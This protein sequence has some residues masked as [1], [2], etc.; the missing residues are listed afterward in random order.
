M[1]FTPI[2]TNVDFFFFFLCV[3]GCCLLAAANVASELW[4]RESVRNGHHTPEEEE[5]LL[6]AG[7]CGPPDRG[8]MV[9]D[10]KKN[11]GKEGSRNLLAC[12]FFRC[13]AFCFVWI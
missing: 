11:R 3:W 12:F 7:H 6:L 2:K 1:K 10:V 4:H 5:K 13:V 8:C 9:L